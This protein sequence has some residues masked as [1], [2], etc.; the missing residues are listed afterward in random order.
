MFDQ[1]VDCRRSL[2]ELARDLDAD[3]LSPTEAV[4]TL[5]HLAAIRRLVD[6]ML[7]RAAK[8]VADSGAHAIKGER[9]AATMIAWRLGVGANEARAAIDTARKLEQLPATDAAVRR[10]ELSARQA[11]MIANAATCNR[12]PRKC[13]PMRQITGCC[14]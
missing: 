2:E 3:A 14:R 11:E 7:A 13:S 4:H 10:G 9:N 6:G 5:D 8:R 1:L 12:P